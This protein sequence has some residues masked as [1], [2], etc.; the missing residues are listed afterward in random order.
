MKRKE[1]TTE[2]ESNGGEEITSGERPCLF[3]FAPERGLDGERGL[4]MKAQEKLGIQ[5]SNIA[6][7]GRFTSG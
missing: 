4:D 7:F 5:Q 1:K 2:G 3:S 6:K